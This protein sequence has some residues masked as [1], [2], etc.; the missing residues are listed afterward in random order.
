[1]RL[2]E[3]GSI[4]RKGIR[5]TSKIQQTKLWLRPYAIVL[6]HI[7]S[8]LPKKL[9]IQVLSFICGWMSNSNMFF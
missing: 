8:L 7:F 2:K 3:K 9:G 1:M 4:L 6:W 5:H